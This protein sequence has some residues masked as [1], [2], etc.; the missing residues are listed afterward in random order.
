M[1]DIRK[2]TTPEDFA[3]AST[4][5]REFSEWH[6]ASHKEDLELIQ[7]YFDEKAFDAELS[8]P[9]KKYV[10]V[11]IASE[12][13]ELCGCVALV[14]LNELDCEMKR[15][16]VRPVHQRKGIGHALGEAILAEA[17]TLGFQRMLLDTSIHQKAA[18]SLYAELG[19]TRRSAYYEM[20]QEVE[21]WLVFMEQA[22]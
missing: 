1:V 3:N 19:F 8:D 5:I 18:Q 14:R 12:S 4:L 21:N 13:D 7:K 22:L 6:R 9:S 20:P 17:R 15:M 2:A 10:S 16:F 11:L